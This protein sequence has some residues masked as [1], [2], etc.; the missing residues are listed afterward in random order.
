V[1]DEETKLPTLIECR[2]ELAL[3][4]RHVRKE[5]RVVDAAI[6]YIERY[7]RDEESRLSL[8]TNVQQLASIAVGFG[9]VIVALTSVLGG[10]IIA[11]TAG[12]LGADASIRSLVWRQ[13]KKELEAR[14]DDFKEQRQQWEEEL[15]AVEEAR[16]KVEHQIGAGQEHPKLLPKDEKRPLPPPKKPGGK[17]RRRR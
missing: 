13:T 16:R 17:K 8:R 4:A 14:I 9:G 5:M 3:W 7:I 2:D 6:T 15:E 12:Y 1:D 11:G 10:I